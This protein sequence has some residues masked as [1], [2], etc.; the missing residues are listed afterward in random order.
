MNEYYRC[1]Q[2]LPLKMTTAVRIRVCRVPLTT[3]ISPKFRV[4]MLV[5]NPPT[6]I[7]SPAR[8]ERMHPKMNDRN[9]LCCPAAAEQDSAIQNS[10]MQVNNCFIPYSTLFGSPK[11]LLISSRNPSNVLNIRGKKNK[12]FKTKFIERI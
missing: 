8:N 5:M 2:R 1:H 4:K 10:D 12:N 7:S 9:R 3:M 6:V 11:H